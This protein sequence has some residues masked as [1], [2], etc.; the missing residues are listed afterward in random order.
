MVL[1]GIVLLYGLLLLF[2]T[3]AFL[4]LPTSKITNELPNRDVSIIVCARNEANH[5]ATC[6]QGIVL[7]DYPPQNLE[8]IFVNDASSDNTLS[9]ATE[10]LQ[11]GK[12][13]F[14]IINHK[15]K[16]GK[17]KSLSEAIDLAKHPFIITRDADTHSRSSQW[18]KAM[19]QMQS[20]KESDFIVAPIAMTNADGLLW[21]LQAVENNILQVISG[22]SNALGKA[23]LCSGANL[24]FTKSIFHRCGG[25]SGHRHIDSGDDVLLLA[26]VKKIKGAGIHF[27]KSPE[28][29][30]DTYACKTYS[31]LLSQKIRWASKFKYQSG[32]LN[33]FLALLT[34]VTNA[35]WL[36]GVCTL[37][38]SNAVAVGTSLLLLI[39]LCIDFFILFVASGFIKTK[40]IA[41]YALPALCL[42]PLYACVVAVASLFIQPRWK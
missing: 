1:M 39:K 4:R 23:F 31:A 38:F 32:F 16:E 18:L 7:Q 13:P 14:H 9:I 24:G 21:A 41:V 25:Y 3:R 40:N 12:I 35:A 30:V 26:D 2:F 19:M 22:G 42:Y 27:L 11:R 33:L 29:I 5:I 15:E 20:S 28:V 36:A 37:F 6:L 17:K 34:F 8:I 10:I